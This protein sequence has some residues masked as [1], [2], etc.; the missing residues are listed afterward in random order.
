MAATLFLVAPKCFG[1]FSPERNLISKSLKHENFRGLPEIQFRL[2]NFLI[3]SPDEWD[4]PPTSQTIKP[5]K[6]QLSGTHDRA[7]VTHDRA[8]AHD[9]AQG[10]TIVQNTLFFKYSYCF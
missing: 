10:H 2:K 9:R 6:I 7:Q 3:R 8:Q 4:M 1:Y 5:G